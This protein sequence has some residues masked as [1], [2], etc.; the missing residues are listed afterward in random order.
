MNFNNNILDPMIIDKIDNSI[1]YDF[2]MLDHKMCDID[3]ID[4][5]IDDVDTGGITSN[6]QYQTLVGGFELCHNIGISMEIVITSVVIDFMNLFR[7]T[8][9]KLFG[10]RHSFKKIISIQKIDVVMNRIFITLKNVIED[11][12]ESIIIISDPV[13]I[14]LNH[15]LVSKLDSLC[16]KIYDIKYLNNNKCT[17]SYYVPPYPD[18][19]EFK[20]YC[21]SKDINTRIHTESCKI[22]HALASPADAAIVNI[23]NEHIKVNDCSTLL[24]LSFDKFRDHEMHFIT[25]QLVNSVQ[26]T[27]YFTTRL[28]KIS[29]I[30]KM[31]IF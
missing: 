5:D 23:V 12:S 4:M 13:N 29:E 2:D 9:E 16:K 10:E 21:D 14:N 25:N 24:I 8:C 22:C 18:E 27:K 26:V 6:E 17:V 31:C 11:I 19:F 30:K 20:K 1:S 3:D 28:E 7:T 15:I